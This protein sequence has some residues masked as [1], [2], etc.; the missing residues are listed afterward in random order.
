MVGNWVLGLESHSPYQPLTVSWKGA[1]T[2]LY[3]LCLRP[4]NKPPPTCSCPLPSPHHHSCALI[5]SGQG[6]AL[7]GPLPSPFPWPSWKPALSSLG[8]FPGGLLALN[9]TLG[10]GWVLKVLGILSWGSW[11]LSLLWSL[12]AGMPPPLPFPLHFHFC[13]ASWEE[14]AYK[15]VPCLVLEGVSLVF[16][17]SQVGPPESQNLDS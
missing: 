7:L 15:E 3:L 12:L 14:K 1:Y 16:S 5:F 10:N 8:G 11:G 6:Q 13:L 9:S 4:D 2:S 17:L